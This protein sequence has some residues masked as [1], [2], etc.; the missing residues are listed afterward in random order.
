MLT[1]VKTIKIM[2]E[3]G[4]NSKMSSRSN[5]DL[6]RIFIKDN[7]TVDSADE[8][9]DEDSDGEG[10]VEMRVRNFAILKSSPDLMFFGAMLS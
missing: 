8:L 4:K 1:E 5:S 10:F 3:I 7:E 6:I 2:S 9:Y